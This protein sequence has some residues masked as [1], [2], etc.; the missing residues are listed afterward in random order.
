MPVASTK[1]LKLMQLV[2][3]VRSHAPT[4]DGYQKLGGNFEDALIEQEDG[5]L[6]GKD[7]CG[8]ENDDRERELPKVGC[9]LGDMILQFT[10][11][12]AH[13]LTFSHLSDCINESSAGAHPTSPIV[14]HMIHVT[15]RPK[16]RTKPIK[17]AQSSARSA[18]E[19]TRDTNLRM[20][21]AAASTQNTTVTAMTETPF[22]DRPSYT[23]DG[24]LEDIAADFSSTW[25]RWSI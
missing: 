8:V 16:D 25:R 7:A 19:T 2:A 5:N 20:T 10:I 23:G 18:E 3:S 6:D 9:Q 17:I 12:P 4:T 15:T 24:G 22:R 11:A 13:K 1:V 14:A 21:K